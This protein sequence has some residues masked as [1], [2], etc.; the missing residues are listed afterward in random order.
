MFK[1]EPSLFNLA[2][3]N[4]YD[5][6]DYVTLGKTKIADI[7]SQ[8]GTLHEFPS[9]SLANNMY[10]KIISVLNNIDLLKERERTVRNALQIPDDTLSSEGIEGFS[11]SSVLSVLTPEMIY[12]AVNE[13]YSAN[14]PYGVGQTRIDA[15]T[16][17]YGVD[18]ASFIQQTI[19]NGGVIPQWIVEALESPNNSFYV[20]NS[21]KASSTINV[22]NDVNDTAA[23]IV[24]LSK[25]ILSDS[26]P[27]EKF[28][29]LKNTYGI[30]IA[31]LVESTINSGRIEV[32]DELKLNIINSGLL[33]EPVSLEEKVQEKIKPENTIENPAVKGNNES[34]PKEIVNV[35]LNNGISFDDA[36]VER[37]MYAY[38]KMVNEFG[39]TDEGAKG[40][41]ANMINE[42]CTLDP[43]KG[44]P[45]KDLG[46]CQWTNI[47]ESSRL[48]K[49]EN[50]C[51]N[52]GYDPT[53][54]DAQLY[55]ADYELRTEYN[56]RANGADYGKLY[57][58]LTG[59][60]Y[61][62]YEDIVENICIYYEG[63]GKNKEEVQAAADV[64]K[65][66]EA[67][68]LLIAV[69]DANSSDKSV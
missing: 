29:E 11:V 20:P 66:N 14:N 32:T 2:K 42:D 6:G 54:M 28:Y 10:D 40:L 48:S 36:V 31:S 67:S 53:T 27:G 65:N 19:N 57:D 63:P 3:T 17:K 34:I 68:Q 49:M 23:K 21:E 60:V 45:G 22:S 51:K 62:G 7:V 30:A 69:I 43:T 55:Y 50:W 52:N 26:D 8:A 39:Y 58:Q 47:D 1:Y 35:R 38:N 46:I 25:M 5:C 16:A 9:A 4:I 59:K 13:I 18:G 33:D 24:E 41:L 56:D 64:R 61:R 12:E 37:I 44:T 15:L